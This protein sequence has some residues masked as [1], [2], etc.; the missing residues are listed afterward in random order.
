M[1]QKIGGKEASLLDSSIFWM[2]GE[3]KPTKNW[4][5]QSDSS[6]FWNINPRD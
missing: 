2:L 5:E 4:W 1:L 3:A 6:I